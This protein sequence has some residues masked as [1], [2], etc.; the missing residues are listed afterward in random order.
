MFLML[1]FVVNF[2]RRFAED[3]AGVDVPEPQQL[4]LILK[5]SQSPNSYN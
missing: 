4:Q 2:D 1:V 5:T 3:G